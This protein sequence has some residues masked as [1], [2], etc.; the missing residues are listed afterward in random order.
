MTEKKKNALILFW[1]GV[2][3]TGDKMKIARAARSLQRQAEIDVGEKQEEFENAQSELEKAKVD[4]KTDTKGGFKKIHEAYMKVQIQK[5][6]YD[7]AVDVYKELF[8]ENP[9]LS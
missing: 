5:K 9:K 3:K 8:E 2:E 7:D 4:A 1:E 6:K